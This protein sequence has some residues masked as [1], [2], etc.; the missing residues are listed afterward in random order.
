MR[1]RLRRRDPDGSRRWR[2]RSAWDALWIVICGADCS[3]AAACRHALR[4]GLLRRAAGGRF[5]TPSNGP[6]RRAGGA[7]HTRPGPL[8]RLWRPVGF[9]PPPPFA[10]FVE[11]H[12]QP[13]RVELMRTGYQLFFVRNAGPSLRA[14][15]R[16]RIDFGAGI[17]VVGIL[18]LTSGIDRQASGIGPF[19]TSGRRCSSRLG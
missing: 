8:P 3:N 15:W 6:R 17:G 18:A 1:W 11:R 5:F 13:Q 7:V 12:A 14:I 16:C 10:S 4:Y 2:A 19:K 9:R